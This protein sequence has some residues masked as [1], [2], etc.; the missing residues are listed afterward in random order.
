MP[1]TYCNPLP[2][3]EFSAS[4]S[5]CVGPQALADPAVIQHDGRWY[6]YVSAAQAWESDD[7]LHWTYRQVDL[8]REVIGPAIESHE[9]WYYLAGNGAKALYR[10]RDPLGPWEDLGPMH[11]HR[12]ERVHWADLYFFRDDDGTFY[13]YHHS[14]TGVG[15]DGVFVTVLDPVANFTR[16]LGPSVHCFA[17]DPAHVWERWGD[18]NEFHDVAW[19]EAACVIKHRGRYYLTYSGCGSEWRR[20]AV[21]CYTA[22]S[23]T[24]PWTY[25]PRSP[26]L[27]ER[28][29]L[30][31]G[32]GHHAMTIG[33]DGNWWMIY[34]VLFAQNHKFDRRLAMDPVGFD[35][36]GRM[37]VRGPT[38][39]PQF[40]PA[41]TGD[42]T[43]DDPGLLPLTINKPATASS[44]APGR[45]PDY[46][47]DNYVR[48][49]WE[50]ADDSLPQWLVVDLLGPFTIEACRLIF[51]LAGAPRQ[52]EPAPYRYRVEVS[53]DGTEWRLASDKTAHGVPRNVEYDTFPPI[54][55]RYVRLTVTD[56][57]RQRRL[58][59]IQITAF[60]RA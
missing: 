58:G 49:W 27:C 2:I 8:P 43:H 46:A 5:G 57:P 42:P 33:L 28:G 35:E 37:I 47:V 19:I 11:D 4:Q 26:L 56:A 23:P 7:L 41:A 21:G 59:L 25:D 55:G 14:G 20:Y 50:A 10:S 32:T 9:G 17:Y 15:S 24:G 54:R 16:A 6:L 13:C 30:L 53:D 44:H 52:S 29:G 3:P 51:S 1:P 48:T 34:H 39:T 45:T 18:A 12:G 40:A 38:E 22:D 36:Q 31:N 60:G